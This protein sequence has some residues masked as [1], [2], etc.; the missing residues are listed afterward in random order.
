MR[1]I[2]MP[3]LGSEHAKSPW[4]VSGTTS[5]GGTE[6]KMRS[7]SGCRGSSNHGDTSLLAL[8]F[9]DF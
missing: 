9:Q 1:P 2:Q 4:I 3:E 8:Y 6:A 5:L 7:H